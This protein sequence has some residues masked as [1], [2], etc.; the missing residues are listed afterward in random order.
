MPPRRVDGVDAQHEL[1]P[2]ITA[3]GE[4]RSDDPPRALLCFRS[5][6]VFEIEDQ[7]VGRQSS[8]F[9]QQPRVR[10]GHIEKA[11]AGARRGGHRGETAWQK[12]YSAA[13]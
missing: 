2:A 11:A 5:Y 8:R 3:F 9:L 13:E 1:A 6:G 7:P 12:S 10:A 4:S